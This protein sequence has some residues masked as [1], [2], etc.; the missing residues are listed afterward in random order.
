[1]TK[2]RIYRHGDR[3]IRASHPSHV[4]AH[5][6]AELGQPKVATQD[7]LEALL[8]SGV[9]VEIVKPVQEELQTAAQD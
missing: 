2:T 4:L 6:A 5:I 1:M 9:K 3:L 8:A 7:D